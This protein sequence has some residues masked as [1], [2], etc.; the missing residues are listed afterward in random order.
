[1]FC[2]CAKKIR[3]IGAPIVGQGWSA[4]LVQTKDARETYVVT[5][6]FPKGEQG[7]MSDLCDKK[8]FI[9]VGPEEVG[10]ILVLERTK[11]K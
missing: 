7:A 10:I 4:Q 6:M 2:S 1:M 3:P 8:S 9:C 5:A 11:K